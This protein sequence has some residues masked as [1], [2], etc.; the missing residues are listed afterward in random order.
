[1]FEKSIRSDYEAERMAI[2]GILIVGATSGLGRGVAEHFIASG[3][4]V[5]VA[6]RN[7][8][9]LG[10]LVALAPDR[11]FS[12]RFDITAADAPDQLETLAGTMG[13]VDIFLHCAGIL[14]EDPE[15][16]D[17]PMRRTVRTNV[18]GFTASLGWAFRHFRDTRRP[19]RIVAIS[20]IAGYR[21]LGD[22]PA[23][24]AS[25]AYDQAFI[26]ALRQ[27]ADAMRLPVRFIDIRPGWTRT[28]LLASD[29]HYLLEMSAADVLPK[30]IRAILRAR[31]SATIGLRWKLLTAVERILPACIWERLHLP[32][33][34]NRH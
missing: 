23:Y 18:E 33:W 19:G 5:G 29:T 27:K 8:T 21:G 11:V 10:E 20:S 12:R 28:P 31:R 6:G 7:C 17:E 1:M 13:E 4:R 15:L 22:I 9:A 34:R 16:P 30:I 3:W 24:S 14:E 26:E 25:K 2:K 32:L